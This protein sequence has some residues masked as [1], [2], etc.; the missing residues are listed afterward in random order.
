MSR[1]RR[2][3][4]AELLEWTG[5]LLVCG[6]V[7]FVYWPAAVVLFGLWMIFVSIGLAVPTKDS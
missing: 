3:P 2:I 1:L 5:V 7:A 4:T 6:G